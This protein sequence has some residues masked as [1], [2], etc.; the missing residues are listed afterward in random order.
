MHKR[1]VIA[2]DGPSGSGK[3]SVA[4]AIAKRFHLDYLDTGAMYRAFTWW[5]LQGR[6]TA[7]GCP[8]DMST[9]PD[10]TRVIVDGHDITSDI[11][12]PEVTERV[13]LVASDPA[14]RAIAVDR[15]RNLIARAVRGIVVEGRDI[16]TV[17]APDADV[18]VFLTADV[19]AREA[20]RAAEFQHDA[21]AAQAVAA[22][23]AAR[24]AIDS[25]RAHSPLQLVEGVTRI[26]TTHAS[27]DEV[28]AMIA[29]LV[30]AA[31][32]TA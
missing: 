1:L 21:D 4:R 27:L 29:E 15:Q 3:S 25:T 10:I 28:V 14:V 18:R 13:S 24:D 20:R 16:T 11:R 30:E 26:D 32:G 2:I 19:E 7:A 8:L 31:G 23:V 12:G 5:N 22:A 6:G 9:N 17:V